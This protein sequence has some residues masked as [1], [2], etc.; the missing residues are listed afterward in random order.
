MVR[1]RNADSN[2]ANGLEE[3]L[4]YATDASGKVTSLV[5][6]AGEV[7][8]RYIYDPYGNVTVLN[9]DWTPQE[10]EGHDP[11]AASAVANDVLYAGY[12]YDAETGLYNVRNRE[13]HPTLGRFIQRDPVGYSAGMNLYSYAA[14]SPITRADPMGLCETTGVPG[15]PITVPCQGPSHRGLCRFPEYRPLLFFELIRVPCTHPC[16]P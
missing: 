2:P 11:G 3:A 16:A 6:A 9:A 7:V 13:Y 10:V 15:T 12:R 4:Y 14:A 5:S 8:E 1:F